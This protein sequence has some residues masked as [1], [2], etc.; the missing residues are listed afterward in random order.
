MI[1]SSRPGFWSSSEAHTS[2]RYIVPSA[3]GPVTSPWYLK[4]VS[5]LLK[6]AGASC[7]LGVAAIPEP[8]PATTRIHK[9]DKQDAP[10]KDIEKVVMAPRS[11]HRREQMWDTEVAPKSPPLVTRKTVAPAP[12]STSKNLEEVVGRTPRSHLASVMDRKLRRQQL[13]A[14]ISRADAEA[15]LLDEEESLLQGVLHRTDRLLHYKQTEVLLAKE[16]LLSIFERAE[17]A[18]EAMAASV[19]NKPGPR[20]DAHCHFHPDEKLT[21]VEMSKALRIIKLE[22]SM[23]RAW[24]Q[25]RWGFVYMVR[26]DPLFIK[27]LLVSRRRETVQPSMLPAG[28]S[29]FS[30]LKA[31]RK[32]GEKASVQTTPAVNAQDPLPTSRRRRPPPPPISINTSFL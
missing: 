18:L 24:R 17:R 3:K 2:Y 21:R 4:D 31:K 8:G 26:R 12:T 16:N 11:E 6:E 29:N 7:S 25:V 30:A 23:T 10:A 15:A 20:S 9:H 5:E 32:K 13:M 19:A 27:R 1:P 28:L 22:E 14:E